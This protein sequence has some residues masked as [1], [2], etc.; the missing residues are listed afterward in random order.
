VV[1]VVVRG[2]R[3]QGLV[4][5]GFDVVVGGLRGQG[6]L[7]CVV[8]VVRSPRSGFVLCGFDVVAIE[9]CHFVLVCYDGC[10]CR[11]HLPAVCLQSFSINVIS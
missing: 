3:G 4:L 1:D 2:L 10:C 6:L 5:C 11:V 9:A 7:L 8:D